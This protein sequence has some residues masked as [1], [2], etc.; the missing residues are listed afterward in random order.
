MSIA[1]AALSVLALVAT[2][3]RAQEPDGELLA[4]ARAILAETPLVDGHNDLPWELRE[5]AGGRLDSLDLTVRHSPDTLDTDLVRLREGMVGA[6]FFADYVPSDSAPHGA[7]FALA[8]AALIRRLVARFPE[9]FRFATTADE[10]EA[11]HEDGRIAALI[12]LEGGHAIEGSLDVLRSL[13]DLG[14]RYI[15]L[16]H[17][18]THDWADSATDAPRHDGLSPFGELVVREMNRLGVMVDLSHVSEATMMDALDIT[19]APVIFSH[20]STRA[21]TDHPRNVPE[22]VLRRLP[23]NGGIIMIT[24]VP[25]FVNEEVRL[26]ETDRDSLASRLRAAFPDDTAG[27]RAAMR[28]SMA[29]RNPAPVATLSDVADHIDYAVEIVGADH[30]GLG[31][32]YDGIDYAPQGLEDVSTFP[33]LLAELLR[34]GYSEEDLAKIA[35]RNALRVM[36][37]VEA[38]A[39]RLQATEE[40]IVASIPSEPAP[41]PE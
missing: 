6:Q 38:A 5:K 16:T 40:P 7:R 30:V 12:G 24:Y 23:Q 25:R 35:G 29:A 19:R 21:L 41:S 15:T 33:A 9:T 27:F 31:S 26:W 17:S 22:A 4:R 34:R 32:D 20:S 1:P 28:D 36:R 18:K 13:H 3:A 10:I 37:Q 2:P 8:Q 39:Q 11:A 14:V